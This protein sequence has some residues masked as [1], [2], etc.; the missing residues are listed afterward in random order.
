MRR[1]RSSDR[2][3]EPEVE[4][5]DRAVGPQLDVGR[6]QIAMDDALLVRRFERLRDL[7]RDRQGLI[8]RESAL[9]RSDRRASAPR[10]VP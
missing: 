1:A 10:P 5:L 6:L 4:H 7:L 2:L 9:A 3:R 8:E